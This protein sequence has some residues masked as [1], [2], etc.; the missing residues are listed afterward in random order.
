MVEGGLVFRRRERSV[1]GG[2]GLGGGRGGVLAHEGE[3]EPAAE[4]LAEQVEDA[5]GVFDVSGQDEV[6]HEDAAFGEIGA[7]WIEGIEKALFGDHEAEGFE[8]D[9][10][11]ALVAHDEAGENG[12]GKLEVGQEDV[13]ERGVAR[14]HGG[15]LVPGGIE[16]EG[17][18]DA[19]V[20]QAGAELFD[21]GPEVI[22]RDEV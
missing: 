7:G 22:G 12:V 21:V 8:G 9:F 11:V 6:A 5:Q 4:F 13:D 16:E 17:N 2:A 20:A 15:E 1:E 14:D 18:P 10:G 19:F 3:G